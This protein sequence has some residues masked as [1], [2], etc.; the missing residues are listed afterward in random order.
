MRSDAALIR[1]MEQLIGEVYTAS[2]QPDHWRVVLRD[3][4]E[5]TES[6][7]SVLMY[8]DNQLEIPSS[9]YYYNLKP[10]HIQDYLNYWGQYDP[11]F[12]L[13][14]RTVPTGIAVADHQMT[15]DRATFETI[16]GDYFTEFMVPHDNYHTAGAFLF[17]DDQRS[18]AVTLQRG[19]AAGPW[20]DE[21]IDRLTSLVPH[22]QRALH[23]HREFSRLRIRE[24]ALRA[25]LNQQ[26]TG[27]ILF[28]HL[29]LPVYCNPVAESILGYHPAISLRNDRL[30]AYRPE[31]TEIL[32]KALLR[33]T[34]TT[35]DDSS[36]H[37]ALG[38]KH[39]DSFTPLPVMIL[40][41][42][43]CSLHLPSG[44]GL[45]HAAVMFSDTERNQ[46]IVPEALITAYGLS[47]SEARV[48]IAVV[49]GLSVNEIAELH[50]LKS[51][52]VKS[53]LL[54]VYRKLGISRQAELVKL[55]LTGPFRVNF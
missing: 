9:T 42:G 20:N 38:L 29:L 8:R 45:A 41:I 54:A 25:G 13:A 21:L 36:R 4:A 46:P 49:N 34:Q 39:P 3:V 16:C 44:D 31:D 50:R 15:P 43:E 11:V 17:N 52:T 48:A 35:P 27:L 26:L 55:L 1:K 47:A 28:D 5:I 40:P 6:R 53:Q 7:S 18:T 22:F 33:A 37:T 14:A 32:H 24:Q 51:S 2:Y 12:D 19:K 10:E 30:C 23:I